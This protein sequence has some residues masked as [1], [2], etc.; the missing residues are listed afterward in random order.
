MKLNL[1]LN[2]GAII[3]DEVMGC[4]TVVILLINHSSSNVYMILN[5]LASFANVFKTRLQQCIDNL[6]E[7]E[8]RSLEEGVN[9]KPFS[10]L[11]E[12]ILMA[13]NGTDL[14]SA[15]AGIEQR[16]L[17]QEESRR[18]INQQAIK[19]RVSYSQLLSWGALGCT[20]M[21]YIVAPMVL[22]II[23]MLGQLL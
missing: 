20:F 23:E 4:Y 21:L 12:C 10:R 16:H 8:I 2:H 14:Q 9:Y 1:M 7:K 6:S 22:A 19:R 17:F 5:W 15:F 18:M 11:I 3:Y 13:Y